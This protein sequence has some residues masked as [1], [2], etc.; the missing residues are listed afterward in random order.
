MCTEG[1]QPRAVH[2]LGRHSSTTELLHLVF[3]YVA[4]AGLPCDPPASVSQVL[5]LQACTTM[6]SSTISLHVELELASKPPL[7]HPTLVIDS[8]VAFY[9]FPPMILEFEHRGYTLSHSSNL[10]L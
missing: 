6:L 9:F 4:Q 5:E 3:C 1:V 10:V 2:V 7:F 8:Q